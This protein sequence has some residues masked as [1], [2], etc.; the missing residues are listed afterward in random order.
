MDRLHAIDA[1]NGKLIDSFGDH[2]LVDLRQGLGRDP[3][4]IHLIQTGTPGQVFGDLIILGSETGEEYGS[5]PG[6]IRAYDVRTGRMVW[7]FHT[8]PHPGEFGYDT[9]PKDAWKYSGGTNC[10]GEM[11]LDERRGIVYIPLGAPT[12]DFYGADRT[13]ANLFADCLIALDART[14]KLIWY[15]QFI[16]HDLWDY[17]PTAAPQ[18][19]DVKHDGQLVPIVAQASKQGFLYVL[20]S[21]LRRKASLANRRAPGGKLRN[22]RRTFL[23]NAAVSVPPTSPFARQSFPAAADIS[24]CSQAR[25]IAGNWKKTDDAV[26]Q[27]LFTPPEQTDTIEFPGNRGGANWGSTASD[28]TKGAMYVVSMDIP[29]ILKNQSDQA[30]SLWDIPESGSP[31]YKGKAVYFSYCQRCHGENRSGKTFTGDSITGK[32]TFRVRRGSHPERGQI[33]P[34]G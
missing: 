21:G 3:D 31:E 26:N 11:S 19:L 23:A 27:G 14:G 8:I 16:H 25:R 13:G 6:D 10:W 29:A 20:N 34:A 9:W 17:D 4:S 24:P 33:R 15:Y 32:C 5:P 7:I 30:P 28:P 2:G 22:A 1:R 12:Y 18:L